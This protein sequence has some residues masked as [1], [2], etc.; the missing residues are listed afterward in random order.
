MITL[1]AEYEAIQTLEKVS[2]SLDLDEQIAGH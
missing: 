1:E 2:P